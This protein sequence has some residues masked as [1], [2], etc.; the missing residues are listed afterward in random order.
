[1]TAEWRAA[2]AEVKASRQSLIFASSESAA[3]AGLVDGTTCA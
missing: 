3:N 1:M 2:S